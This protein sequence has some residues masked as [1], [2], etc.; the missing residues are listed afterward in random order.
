MNQPP[1]NP[2]NPP[3]SH[4]PE[5]VRI[6]ELRPEPWPG[7]NRVKV[8]VT[9]VPRRARLNLEA[10]ISNSL[11][12]KMSSVDIVEITESKFVFTMHLPGEKSPGIYLLKT[13][14]F[15]ESVPWFD[16]KEVSFEIS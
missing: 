8:H 16:E 14:L 1:Q 2:G 13:R 9:L 3:L 4:S 10:S 7:S 6:L 12:E 15:S 5:D 11:G